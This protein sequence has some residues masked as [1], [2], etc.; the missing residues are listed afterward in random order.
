MTPTFSDVPSGST[1]YKEIEW[2]STTGITTGF[3][4]PSGP[5]QFRPTAPVTRQAMAAFLHRFSQLPAAS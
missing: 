1:F 5:P 2:L 4:Q 3:A